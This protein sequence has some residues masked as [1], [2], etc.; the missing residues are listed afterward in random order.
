MSI[1]KAAGLVRMSPAQ[2]PL[3]MKFKPKLSQ[4]RVHNTIL[5]WSPSQHSNITVKINTTLATCFGF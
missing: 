5:Y 3:Y 1:V 2:S 4:E